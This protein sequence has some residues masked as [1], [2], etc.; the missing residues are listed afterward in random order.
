MFYGGQTHS[1]FLL[2]MSLLMKSSAC[3]PT[4]S[5]ALQHNALQGDELPLESEVVP[6]A[7]KGDIAMAVKNARCPR[8]WIRR[9]FCSTVFTL[10][11]AVGLG[12]VNNGQQKHLTFATAC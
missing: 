5:H 12:A 9:E 7:M 2:S 4:S 10:L 1:I 11:E 6:S 3:R 8:K